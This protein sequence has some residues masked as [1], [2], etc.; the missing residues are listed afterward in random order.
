[1]H[2]VSSIQISKSKCMRFC[3]QLD[4]LKHITH[5]EFECLNSLPVTYI[6]KQCINTIVLSISINNAL[7]I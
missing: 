4:K 7:I 3:L 2:V 5:E 1:M 6:F